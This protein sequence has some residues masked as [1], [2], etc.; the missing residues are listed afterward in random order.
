MKKNFTRI[1]KNK[2]TA[3][4]LALIIS[5]LFI[6]QTSAS[7]LYLC[8]NFSSSTSGKRYCRCCPPERSSNSRYRHMGMAGVKSTH[9][10]AISKELLQQPGI[11][12][13]N[14]RANSSVGIQLS[15]Q[16]SIPQVCCQIEKPK[17]EMT[18]PIISLTNVDFV[19]GQ[20]AAI[21]F[22]RT[23]QSVSGVTISHPRSRPVY[24]ILSTFLI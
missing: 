19:E 17:A 11:D 18:D 9:C 15:D 23:S 21:S 3:L 14:E 4:R 12:T 10:K 8:D 6:Q 1:M 7:A 2:R 13:F 24:L 16:F 20:S 22:N 5:V